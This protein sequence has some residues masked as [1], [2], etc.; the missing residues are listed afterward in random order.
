MWEA[1][2]G[3]PLRATV[4]GLP[5]GGAGRVGSPG[6]NGLMALPYRGDED[7]PI[8]A[9]PSIQ[10]WAPTTIRPLEEA[11]PSQQDEMPIGLASG[12]VVPSRME[13]CA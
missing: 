2:R 1:P 12:R 9:V 7:H 5:E 8:E 4:R 11:V 6:G 13:G 3:E 10:R